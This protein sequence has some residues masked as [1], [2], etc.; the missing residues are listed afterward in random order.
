MNVIKREV[1]KMSYEELAKFAKEIQDEI[2]ILHEKMEERHKAYEELTKDNNLLKDSLSQAEAD[3]DKLKQ[4]NNAKTLTI[5]GLIAKGDQDEERY[6]KLVQEDA[7]L[8][9]YFNK[10]VE[11]NQELKNYI[12]RLEG[13]LETLTSREKIR[14]R[15]LSIPRVVK[16]PVVK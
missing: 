10:Q 1:R 9:S 6:N 14:P 7:K 15:C 16:C 4:D 11:E 3:V 12:Y 5:K 13:T 8:Q 2:V